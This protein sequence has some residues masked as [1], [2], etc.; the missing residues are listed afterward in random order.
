[1]FSSERTSP[2][3]DTLIVHHF[4]HLRCQRHVSA[5]VI[6][7]PRCFALNTIQDEK[8][9]SFLGNPQAADYYRRVEDH[10]ETFSLRTRP[11]PGGKQPE[12]PT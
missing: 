8:C 3:A 7:S 5:H 11:F 1:M 4:R 10:P 6:S 9:Q 12:K 2:T